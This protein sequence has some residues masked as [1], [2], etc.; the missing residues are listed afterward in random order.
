MT[1]RDGSRRNGHRASKRRGRPVGSIKLT[2]E[3]EARIITY[4]EAGSFDYVAAEAVGIDERTFRDYVQRGSR[5]AVGR[6]FAHHRSERLQP[7]RPLLTRF[8]FQS[9]P[10]RTWDSQP[11]AQRIE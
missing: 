7:I 10:P 8:L 2:P 6:Q 5:V 11:D 9:A 4:I 1:N 3:A